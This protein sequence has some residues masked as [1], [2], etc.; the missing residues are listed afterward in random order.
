MLLLLDYLFHCLYTR[1][2]GSFVIYAIYML[3]GSTIQN[4][5]LC[6]LESL[7]RTVFQTFASPGGKQ[8][9][10]NQKTWKWI[11]FH[12]RQIV[13]LEALGDC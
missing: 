5:L 6:A 11:H 1:I 4:T 10:F 13:S 9:Q 7:P 12:P 2:H 3:F 8:E